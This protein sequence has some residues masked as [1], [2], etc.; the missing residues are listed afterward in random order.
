MTA[1]TLWDY[2]KSSASYRVRIAL[3]LASIDYNIEPVDLPSKVHRS[4]EH[5]ARTPPRIGSSAGY[6][7]A[8]VHLITGYF[9]LSGYDP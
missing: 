5:L 4:P 3:N 8:A 7:R 9:G 2:P 6:R 1:A